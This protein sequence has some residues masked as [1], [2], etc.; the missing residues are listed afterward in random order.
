MCLRSAPEKYIA[1]SLAAAGATLDRAI[2]DDVGSSTTPTI[3]TSRPVTG[4]D[5]LFFVVFFVLC[6]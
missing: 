5:L 2:L 6:L 4:I 1:G 3:Y